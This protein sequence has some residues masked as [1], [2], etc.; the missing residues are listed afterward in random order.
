MVCK[1][2]QESSWFSQ[3]SIRKDGHLA[4]VQVQCRLP[5]GH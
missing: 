4:G 2:N 1:A 5:G 3:P